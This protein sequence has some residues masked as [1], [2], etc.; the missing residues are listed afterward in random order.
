MGFASVSR[1]SWTLYNGSVA[2]QDSNTL[3]PSP[4]AF[5]VTSAKA[6]GATP[7]AAI[8]AP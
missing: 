4:V 7:N 6:L 3:P 2:V 5:K 8:T 1:M